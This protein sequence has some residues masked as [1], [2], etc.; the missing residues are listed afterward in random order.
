MR[1]KTGLEDD[2]ESS[3]SKASTFVKGKC[4]SLLTMDNFG[5]LHEIRLVLRKR[6]KNINTLTNLGREVSLMSNIDVLPL[7]NL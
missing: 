5:M 6:Y 7:C 3:C 1:E 4:C 2:G